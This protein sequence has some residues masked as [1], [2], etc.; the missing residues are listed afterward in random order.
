MDK[1][2]SYLSKILCLVVLLLITIPL[3][4][5]AEEKEFEKIF[6]K[7]MQG[8]IK[9]TGNTLM[10]P[11]GHDNQNSNAW[12][13]LHGDISGKEASNNSFIMKLLDEDD[14]KTTASSSA[15]EIVFP[16]GAE[17]EKAFLVWGAKTDKNA[18]M[19][20]IKLK[21]PKQNSEYRALEAE[22]VYVNK[23]ATSLN[24]YT[25]YKDVTEIVKDGGS[26][27]YWAADSTA[28]TSDTIKDL[29]A[30]WSLVV[31]FKDNN[32]PL[33]SL[34][35]YFGYKVVR[36]HETIQIEL[37]DLLTPPKGDV[38]A[39]TGIVAWEGD[40]GY[41]NDRFQI[42]NK[43]G[44]A[45]NL[46][47]A[48]SPVNNFFNSTISENGVYLTNRKP[49][50]INNMAVDAKVINIDNRIA[51]SAK[52]VKFLMRSS[53]EWYY[54]T[55]QTFEIGMYS[56][57]IEVDKKIKTVNDKAPGDAVK[58][59]D[60]IE[61]EILLSNQGLDNAIHTVASDVL[62]KGL[63]YVP[64]TMSLKDFKKNTDYEPQ[65]DA[66]DDDRAEY[67]TSDNKIQVKIGEMASTSEGV[68]Q[69]TQFGIKFKAK[70][71]GE[72]DIGK[73]VN[74]CTVRC[75]GESGAEN[76]ETNGSDSG[77]VVKK[78]FSATKIWAG[79]DR[80]TRPELEFTLYRK[81]EG[82]EAT[83]VDG[84]EVKEIDANS[85]SAQW[86]NLEV[87][88]ENGNKYIYFVKENAKEKS[89]LNDN[90][91]FGAFDFKTN[92]I[93]NRVIREGDS[94]NPDHPNEKA[95]KLTIKKVLGEESQGGAS[96][97]GTAPVK[98]GFK[99]SGPYGYEKTFELAAGEEITLNKI[100]Y[101]EYM[102]EETQAHGYTPNYSQASVI[103]SKASP[104]A[105]IIVTNKSG[106]EEVNKPHDTDTPD[107]PVKP[108]K[109]V[110]RKL[111]E[112]GSVIP[113]VMCLGIAISMLGVFMFRK[114]SK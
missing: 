108:D 85:R 78:D 54:P 40:W 3:S 61:Y 96:E 44:E 22:E 8:S 38:L 76:I 99:V 110:K 87:T 36:F 52:S 1:K 92:T 114:K 86:E 103:L 59:G 113:M 101:G 50:F 53:D 58:A 70:V 94:E 41:Q 45:E 71:T 98:F 62:P 42:I 81:I 69:A 28:Y 91:V 7:N 64:N 100:Y 25:A 107:A 72:S 34:S 106:E 111:P 19:P 89:V 74:E 12:K 37:K 109:L 68:V 56:P 46:F 51:N 27:W 79:D 47:D 14:D 112:M 23:G 80:V 93:T 24:H 84:A 65:T 18:L 2:L 60:I 97:K 17:V 26:G 31:V 9:I 67:D 30:G 73:I 32:Q 10:A 15:A 77:I 57:V 88:D 21:S 35:V 5:N 49:A 39:K 55:V 102:V 33:N 63:V 75:D 95:A 82:G 90:W 16:D 29:Y 66:V 6:Q 48:A 105:T 83:K 104:E 43:E 20:G 11:A 4:V 13:A